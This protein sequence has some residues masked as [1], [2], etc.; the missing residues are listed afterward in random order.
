MKGLFSRRFG[1]VAL[2]LAAVAACAG[3]VWWFSFTSTLDQLG[4]RGRADLALS[5]DRL[6][7]QMRRYREL[8]VLLSDHPT[9]GALVAGG[10]DE[11]L[12]NAI[13][14]L[15][16][17]QTG[18]QEIRLL[19]G[20]GTLLASAGE[21][22]DDIGARPAFRRA[23]NGALGSAHYVNDQGQRLFTFGAPVGTPGLPIGG[24]IL[25]TIDLSEI[26]WNWPSDPF[27]VFFTDDTGVVYVTSRSE[28]ILASRGGGGGTG[29]FHAFPPYDIQTVAG[30]RLWD[31][32]G[33]RYLPGQAMHLTQ[34]MP[35]IGMTGEILI[36]TAPARRIAFLQSAVAGALALAI[37]AMF[38]VAAERRR[39][40]AEKLIAEAAANARLEARVATRT[41]ELSTA[42]ETLR[43]AQAD[44]V[45]ADKLTAL[46]QMSAGISHELNQPLMAIRSFA[47][48]AET[49]LGRGKPEAAGENLS[50]ISELARR[51]GRIIKNLRAFA[52]QEREEITDVDLVRVVD[53]VL[54][55]AERRL[56]DGGV[57]VSW[58]RPDTPA[59]VR[60][61]EVRL[62]QVVMNLAS[63]AADAMVD[64]DIRNLDISIE[65][66]ADIVMLH[67]RDT[68]PGIDDP[69]KIFDPFYSTKEVGKS[70][71]M[72]LGLSISYGL[73]QS[74]GGVIRGRNMAV[75][76]AEFTVELTR[77]N[78]GGV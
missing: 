72:G 48:N 64:S 33:G 71:G 31:I 3:G 60:G 68:G 63:N 78:V 17:D 30:H 21:D 24:A 55:L 70:E 26:E 14:R 29:V 74:F 77:A 38:Y 58:V 56:A 36:D 22:Y 57:C 67:V 11:Q 47:E 9:L 42:N 4:I 61:G 34:P 43:K 25:V 20:D 45:Q 69:G 8:A 41:A 1:A 59:M 66:G 37:G 19:A 54:E 76:G 44:L 46:G 32:D 23:M 10:G 28:L 40:M 35:V 65:T 5:S 27:A 39:T 73:V 12:A 53:A 2:F 51:M 75:G 6:S 15:K 52:R 7:A 50:R 18:T 13:L 62:Q 16:A 49:Y